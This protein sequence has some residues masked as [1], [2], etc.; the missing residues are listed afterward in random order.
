MAKQPGDPRLPEEFLAAFGG[1]K[2]YLDRVSPRLAELLI[3]YGPPPAMPTFRGD[4]IE[5][6]GAVR[7]FERLSATPEARARLEAMERYFKDGAQNH[8]SAPND[9]ADAG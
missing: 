6:A 7:Q 4:V 5:Y 8:M 3:A 2:K 9:V 1:K